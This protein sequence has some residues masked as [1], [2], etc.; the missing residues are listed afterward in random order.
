MVPSMN[1]YLSDSKFVCTSHTHIYLL[2]CKIN[3]YAVLNCQK[4]GKFPS[5]GALLSGTPCHCQ[6]GTTTHMALTCAR[7]EQHLR[8][9]RTDTSV[10]LD[11]LILDICVSSNS[12]LLGVLGVLGS[13][14]DSE[15]PSRPEVV[16]L[17][18]TAPWPN[19]PLP[20][21]KLP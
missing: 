17:V 12:W 9:S 7:P 6:R 15:T 16:A 8:A 10:C 20:N 21:K 13:L 18:P 3:S 1:I 14:M 4:P 2:A 5:T 19:E 11:S